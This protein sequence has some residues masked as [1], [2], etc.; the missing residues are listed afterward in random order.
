MTVDD[1]EVCC[2]ETGERSS[3]GFIHPWGTVIEFRTGDSADFGD[4]EIAFADKRRPGIIIRG[5]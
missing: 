2:I 1:V 4:D 3:N 5:D